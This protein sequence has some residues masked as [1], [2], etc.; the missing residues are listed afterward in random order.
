MENIRQ[1]L[2]AQDAQLYPNL[3]D[4]RSSTPRSVMTIS[5]SS[6]S[7]SSSSASSS[8]SS[9]GSR[10]K[11]SQARRA[12]VISSDEEDEDDDVVEV[13]PFKPSNM[14]HSKLP[15]T[16]PVKT[17]TINDGF[18]S[19]PLQQPLPRTMQSKPLPA[20]K[21]MP[22][23]MPIR[24][25]FAPEK[26]LPTVPLHPEDERDGEVI[27]MPALEDEN[28]Y[29]SPTDADK[30]LRELMSGNMNEDVDVEIN[31]E[32]AI[33]KGFKEGFTLLPHQIIG[34]N[35]MKEREN[36]SEKKMGGILADDMGLGKTIQ[37]LTRIVEG[38]PKKKDREDGWS[39]TTLVVCPLALVAQWA[40]EIERM[41]VGLTVIKHQG[42]SRTH[43]PK[44][45]TNAHVVVTT[46]DTVKSEYSTYSPPAKDESKSKAKKKQAV[47]DT[48]SSDG[49]HFGRTLVKN[50]KKSKAKPK[51]ALFRIRWFRVVLDEAHNIKNRSTQGAIACCELEAKFRWA[52]TGTPLQNDVTEIYSLFKFL[53]IKPFS[54]WDH[55]NEN[56]AKRI[57]SGNGAN[58]A[59][60]R[61]QVV[62]KQIML[63]RQ[64]TDTM[65][66]KVLIELPQRIVNIISCDFSPSEQHF[67]DDLEMKMGDVKDKLMAAAER[68]GKNANYMAVLLLL[69][70]LRQACN[71]PSL[72]SKDYKVDLEAVESQAAKKASDETDGDD[73]VA[74]FGALGVTRK[75]AICTVELTSENT[76][77]SKV[78]GHCDG[79]SVLAVQARQQSIARPDSAKIRKILEL[80]RHVDETSEGK[81]KTIIFSQFT[82]MLDLIQPFL[83]DKGIRFVRYDGS[84]NSVDR[85]KSIE[86][87]KKDDRVKVILISFKAGSTGLNLTACNNVIL[88]D[89][90][91]NPALEDQAFDRA[92]RFGQLKDVN[93][94]KLKIDATVE[95]R[96]LELQDKKRELARAALSGD[97]IKNIRLGL[98]DL[99]ALFRPGAGNEDDDD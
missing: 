62:L 93:I 24:P 88:V 71:H 36:P 78:E 1:R 42:T 77:T 81:D 29:M 25:A 37:A 92:H 17:P 89:L 63:R 45:L 11:P 68:E 65:N 79:C 52:L 60:K 20:A 32:D 99:M 69:L 13:A 55:F 75:C 38:R 76:T 95:D 80:L 15:Q 94:Y 3:K 23:A 12:I 43:D 28:V 5:S 51:D 10:T 44:V 8:S 84:M 54:S 33:V 21:T 31:P 27:K 2:M 18:K 30:A 22:V 66:G 40:S 85:E 34:R 41:C 74:A 96:I 87:I 53:R 98:D 67:Y 7:S 14:N 4:A 82:S 46:Y 48:D 59:M 35:W 56:I 83:K 97:K 26:T 50:T 90:W 64:K 39:P 19:K 58:R 9:N 70:R 49:E 86:A 61:L 57:K 47:D 73:L 72:V 91:W 6:S 16:K